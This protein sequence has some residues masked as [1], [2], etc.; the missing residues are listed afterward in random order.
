[1]SKAKKV[2]K[3]EAA[4]QAVAAP[5][6]A[7]AERANAEAKDGVVETP[8]T[9]AEQPF[10]PSAWMHERIVH[11]I[12]EFEKN[13]VLGSDSRSGEEN[14]EPRDGSHAAGE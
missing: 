8:D 1:M 7:R 12:L 11:Q 10:D 5:A 6:R 3:D 9:P 14:R 2:Q 4:A 13:L